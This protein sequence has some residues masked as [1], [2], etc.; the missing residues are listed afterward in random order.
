MA[1]AACPATRIR[2]LARTTGP[3]PFV[4]PEASY[5]KIR[6]TAARVESSGDPAAPNWTRW[7]WNYLDEKLSISDMAMLRH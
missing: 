6:G 5:C 2:R 7:L 4:R 1:K 3:S